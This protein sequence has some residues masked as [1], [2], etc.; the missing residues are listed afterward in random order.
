MTIIKSSE[1][2]KIYNC[3]VCDYNTIRNSQYIRHLLTRK[4]KILSNTTIISSNSSTINN[5]HKCKCGK[6]Y[7]HYSSLWNHKKKC[8]YE[9]SENKIIN[10]NEEE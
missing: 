7:K 5:E 6:I 4:H 10:K 9:E 3:E 1:C 8:E 2:S